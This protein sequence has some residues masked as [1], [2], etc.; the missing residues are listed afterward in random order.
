MKHF[1][2]P[3]YRVTLSARE[4]VELIW[5]RQ[6]EAQKRLDQSSRGMLMN[7]TEYD[8]LRDPTHNPEELCP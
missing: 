6:I 4:W 7:P 1:Y 3:H 8:P 2:F 5:Q